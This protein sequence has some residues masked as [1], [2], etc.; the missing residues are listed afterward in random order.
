LYA[1]GHQG[2]F[3]IDRDRELFPAST[4]SSILH[5]CLSVSIHQ[6]STLRYSL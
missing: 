2:T 3:S 5:I 4:T 6:L 1:Q